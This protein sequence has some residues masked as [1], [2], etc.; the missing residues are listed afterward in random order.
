MNNRKILLLGFFL[1]SVNT[2]SDSQTCTGNVTTVEVAA[3][4]NIHAS[5][6]D[7]GGDTNFH[8]VGICRVTETVGEF[9]EE[10]CKAALTLL[11]TAHATGKEVTLWFREDQ[12]SSCTQSW[13]EVWSQGVYHL[14]LKEN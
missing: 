13:G 14:R 9:A 3:N 12:F 2:Y 8:S 1:A 10:S 4:G 5:I 11:T 6:Q 7:S